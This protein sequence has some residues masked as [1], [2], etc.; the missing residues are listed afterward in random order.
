MPHVLG[1]VGD[2]D[3]DGPDQIRASIEEALEEPRYRESVQRMNAAFG[4]YAREDV[5]IRRVETLLR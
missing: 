2:R 4:R 5:A 1:V 3:S